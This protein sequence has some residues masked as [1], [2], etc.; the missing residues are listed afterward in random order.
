VCA[1]RHPLERWR[2]L[3]R[4][5]RVKLGPGPS[6][7]E[8]WPSGRDEDGDV[9]GDERR[10]DGSSTGQPDQVVAPVDP[11]RGQD[12]LDD[13]GRFMELT[14]EMTEQNAAGIIG[15]H[16]ESAEPSPAD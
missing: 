15:V 14:N 5:G 6:D 9:D 7:H 12:M 2:E 8:D 13:L 4:Q 16:A 3:E 11:T 10:R 1:C